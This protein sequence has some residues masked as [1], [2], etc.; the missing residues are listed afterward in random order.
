MV[1]PI[2]KQG[3]KYAAK[4]P[5]VKKLSKEAFKVVKEATKQNLRYGK[6]VMKSAKQAMFGV[7]GGSGK[8]VAKEL[9]TGAKELTSKGFI[10]DKAMK[11]PKFK[12]ISVKAINEA[13]KFFKR[14]KLKFRKTAESLRKQGLNTG[15]L[16]KGLPKLAKKGWK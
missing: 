16:I 4:N 8:A 15:G 7:P 14:K 5:K 10:L 3:V 2:L 9:K 11:D 1:Y 6:D 13:R 12:D